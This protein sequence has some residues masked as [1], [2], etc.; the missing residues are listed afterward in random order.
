MTDYDT[1]IKTETVTRRVD[2][3][4]LRRIDWEVLP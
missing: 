2:T 1:T 3:L 4:H